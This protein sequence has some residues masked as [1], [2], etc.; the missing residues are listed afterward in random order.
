MDVQFVFFMLCNWK[1]YW[2]GQR[3]NRF[4]EKGFDRLVVCVCSL[5]AA[6]NDECWHHIPKARKGLEFS[7]RGGLVGMGN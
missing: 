6:E 2:H 7:G 4:Y 5:N 1:Y 3:L